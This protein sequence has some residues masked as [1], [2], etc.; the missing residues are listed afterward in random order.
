M[1]YHYNAPFQVIQ[2][3]IGVS[4]ETYG[5]RQEINRKKQDVSRETS[6]QTKIPG[7]NRE[8]KDMPPRVGV[9]QNTNGQSRRKIILRS[10]N[11][12]KKLFGNTN[13]EQ[14]CVVRVLAVVLRLDARTLHHLHGP[15][16]RVEK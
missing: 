14:N 2:Q 7:K 3:E 4:R 8:E 11:S 6:C 1:L 5:F 10:V 12:S 13:G 15:A 9:K 16:H